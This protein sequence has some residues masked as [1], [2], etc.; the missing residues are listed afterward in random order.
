MLIY[1]LS[2]LNLYIKQLRLF[3]IIDQNKY[4]K[5][6]LRISL[7]LIV[8]LP[9]AIMSQLAVGNP[10]GSPAGHAND[11]AGNNKTCRSCHSG[12]TPPTVDAITANIPVIGYTPGETYAITI[13]VTEAGISRF[14]FQATVQNT[15]GNPAGTIALSNTTETGLVGSNLYVT[16]RSAGTSGSGSKSWLFNWTAPAAGFGP[17]TV[18]SSTM[19][20]N[21]NGNN[22]GDNVYKSSLTIQ[23][24][25]TVSI[26]NVLNTGIK[27][28]PNP[29]QQFVFI[30]LAEADL[31]LKLVQLY[32]LSG[33]ML[34][35]ETI[36]PN[37]VTIDLSK[38][39]QGVYIARVITNKG[40]FIQKII[41]Q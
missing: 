32:N 23:E 30:E 12:A 7:L 19:A 21:N 33:K 26:A 38:F 36:T 16:H 28:Y 18:Y 4:M 40:V 20:A 39:N 25:T 31:Q 1:L 14:G 11:P 5:T 8:M 3:V 27:M 22:N 29:T 17:A 2:K 41:K 24:N 15:S 37:Q 13:T 6:F 10:N 34:L 35:S 9:F